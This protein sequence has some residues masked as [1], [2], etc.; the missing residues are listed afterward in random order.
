MNQ[1]KRFLK[2]FT[3]LL[4]SAA[5]S[6]ASEMGGLERTTLFGT[7]A[8]SLG[9]GSASVGL[10][11]DA[12]AALSSNPALLTT[13]SRGEAIFL[14]APLFEGAKYEALSAVLPT[15]NSGTF[16]LSYVDVRSPDI[17]SR[18]ASDFLLGTFTYSERQFT[19]EYA[20]PLP[21]KGLSV[22]ASGHWYQQ[23]IATWSDESYGFDLGFSWHP[24]NH[25]WTLGLA[26]Q[27]LFDS[28]IK[29]VSTKERPS[30]GIL[31]GGSYPF[32]VPGGLLTVAA[33]GKVVD[34]GGDLLSNT[35]IRP[36]GGV[37]Y[38]WRKIGALRCG[39]DGDHFNAGAGVNVSSWTV[40]Y[41][42]A[43]EKP[44]G[45]TH[46]LSAGFYFGKDMNEARKN[47]KSKE[48]E[49]K[50][51]ILN[52]LKSESIQTYLHSGDLAYSEKRYDDAKAE[53]EKV[54][55]WD[56]QNAD[57]QS[58]LKKTDQTAHDSA[59]R[60]KLAEAKSLR[61]NDNDLDAMVLYKSVLDIDPQNPDATQGLAASGKRLREIS[62][63]AFST[64]AS[65]PPAEAQAYFEKGLEHYLAGRY[66][67]A[68]DQWKVLVATNPLQ[69]QVFDYVSRAQVRL[70]SDKAESM[71][72]QKAAVQEDRLKLLKQKAFDQYR[73]SDLKGAIETWKE[74][75][76]ND[77]ANTEAK[78][79]L[80]KSQAE[81]QNS[82]KRGVRW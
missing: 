49:L 12:G 26:S 23:N 55:A 11:G 72:K 54:L 10:S 36:S 63:K 78:A 66:S 40:Q 14:H 81:L 50:T 77:P 61:E 57:A 28:G 52:K 65:L 80:E 60:T 71:Q 74:V 2:I 51:E 45:I 79:E 35:I 30:R 27:N 33:E 6:M 5:G 29:L 64:S 41:A 38:L 58:R 34:G 25:P 56:P 48:E 68:M 43:F 75:L 22:G 44:A 9:L 53:Y 24:E 31:L 46:R 20:T 37:E 39:W 7:D 73:K 76:K 59:I 62:R 15:M 17:E 21:L 70:E 82:L 8:R 4:F 47:R 1:P 69:R 19:L 16:A 32:V 13:L 42:V 3:L 67:Q 18:D